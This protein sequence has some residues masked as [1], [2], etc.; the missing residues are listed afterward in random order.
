MWTR[1]I[2]PALISPDITEEARRIAS[3]IND[4]IDLWKSAELAKSAIDDAV[5][6]PSEPP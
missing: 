1:A 6:A 3:A 4:T 2:L 5:A